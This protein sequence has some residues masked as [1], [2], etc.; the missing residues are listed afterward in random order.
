[1]GWDD[2][3]E[4]MLIEF[5]P[6]EMNEEE[7]LALVLSVTHSIVDPDWDREKGYEYYYKF[8]TESE[9]FDIDK[10]IQAVELI[11]TFKVG[12]IG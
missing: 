10:F 9:E 4:E 11:K 6:E 5:I 12:G 3:N 2:D 8:L 1:M 7:Q